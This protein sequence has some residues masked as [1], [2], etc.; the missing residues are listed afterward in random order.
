MFRVT[1]VRR[2][3]SVEK[4]PTSGTKNRNY[5][6]RNWESCIYQVLQ[7]CR[8]FNAFNFVTFVPLD[9]A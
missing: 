6:D 5:D 7:G 9:L 8:N 4:E 1:E 3:H 2:T